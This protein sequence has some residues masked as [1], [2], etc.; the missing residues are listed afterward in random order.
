MTKNIPGRS[1]L[2]SKSSGRVVKFCELIWLEDHTDYHIHC[3]IHYLQNSLT[4]VDFST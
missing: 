4:F 1:G 3:E 2:L